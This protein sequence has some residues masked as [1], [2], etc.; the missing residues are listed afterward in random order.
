MRKF[1]SLILSSVIVFGSGGAASA[2]PGRTDANG[3]HHCWTN[4][5]KW[6]LEYGQYHYHNGGSSSYTPA[7]TASSFD[8]TYTTTVPAVSAPKNY[9]A[10][11][12]KKKIFTALDQTPVYSQPKAEENLK[13][14]SIPYGLEEHNSGNIDSW[15]TVRQAN[16]KRV[17]ISSKD[18]VQVTLYNGYTQDTPYRIQPEKG[19]VFQLPSTASKVKDSLPKGDPVSVIGSSGDWLYVTYWDASGREQKGFIKNTIIGN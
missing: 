3:G 16:G 17:Y 19:Y 14:F 2:H 1:A 7:G 12:V 9:V 13:L 11:V 5:A 8:E 15:V 4:C 6:G 18:V 10:P